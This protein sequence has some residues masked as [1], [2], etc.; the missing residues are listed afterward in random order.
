METRSRDYLRKRG[1]KFKFNKLKYKTRFLVERTNSWLKN[2]WNA[3]AKIGLSES[4]FP[5][6]RK[7]IIHPLNIPSGNF[8]FS[9]CKLLS[10]NFAKLD[11]IFLTMNKRSIIFISAIIVLFILLGLSIRYKSKK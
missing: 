8:Y 7:P 10:L 11:I 9:Y 1:P 2:F 3:E 4:C 6:V 5:A